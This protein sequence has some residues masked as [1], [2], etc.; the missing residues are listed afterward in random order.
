MSKKYQVKEKVSS[1]LVEQLL[2]NRG[3]LS[4]EEQDKFLRPDFER[5]LHDP[6]LL[7][8]MERAV[9][10]ILF[11]ID[12]GERIGI[13]SDYDADGIPGAALLHDFFKLLGFNNFINYIP[14]RHTEGYGLNNEGVEE[15]GKDGVKLLITI[16][17]GIRDHDEIDRAKVLGMDVIV[18]DHHESGEKLPNAFAVVNPKR[19]DSKYPEKILCGSG[20]IWKLIEALRLTLFARGKLSQ[21]KTGS[22]KWLL[23]L[24]GL[25][26]LSDMVPLTGENRSL[27]F[28]GLKVL[29]KTKRYGLQKLYSMLKI[30]VQKLSEDDIGFLITPRIN[31]ASRMGHPRDAFN[32]LVA[33]NESDADICARHLDTI[34]NE[35]KGMVASM[36]KEAKKILNR[37][38]ENEGDKQ[39]VVLGN[40]D[41]RPSLLGLAANSITEEYKRPVFLWGRENGVLIKGSCRSYGGVDLVALMERSKDIFTDF[42]GHKMSGG[43]SLDFD[44]VHTLE[45]SLLKASEHTNTTPEEIF[46][47]AILSLKNINFNTAEQIQNLAPFGMGNEKPVFILTDVVPER[48]SRFGKN[49]EHLSVDIREGTKTVRAISFFTSI[50]KYK[51][52]LVE[53]VRTNL[54]ANLEL[55][56]WRGSRPDIRLRIIDFFN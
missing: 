41:W 40:P 32:L 46:T 8:D 17:C 55:S 11:A 26:T 19:S 13:W 7:P 5:D 24:V 39:L 20:V 36:V 22:H 21:F 1:D 30:N 29:R 14:N 16:D 18:T 2:H 12:N 25:A 50:D 47:D 35:R 53:G 45:E 56:Y 3:I 42:G 28:F 27:S 37:K 43:F 9:D 6:F 49:K 44:K 31:A 51:N 33:Q 10:R 54:V 34:N 48:I 38:I 4:R 23:D 15:L 52:F